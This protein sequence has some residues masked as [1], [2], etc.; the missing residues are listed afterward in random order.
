MTNSQNPHERYAYEHVGQQF[1]MYCPIEGKPT[2]HRYEGQLV[3]ADE[4]SRNGVDLS[5][6]RRRGLYTCM[7]DCKSTASVENRTLVQ[8]AEIQAARMAA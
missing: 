5:K 7:G 4:L 2:M 3:A 6:H 1:R 8:D